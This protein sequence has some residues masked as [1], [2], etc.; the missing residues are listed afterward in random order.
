MKVWLYVLAASNH[1]DRIRCR[2]PWRVDEHLIY[3]GPCK[4][5]IRACLRGKY[6]TSATSHAVAAEDLFIVG[7]NG[8][9]AERVRKI[10]WWGKLLEVMTFAYAYDHLRG[11][12]FEE[13]RRHRATPL[14]VRPIIDD[15]THIGYE[16][17]SEEHIKNNEWISDVVSKRSLGNVVLQDRKLISRQVRAGEIFDRDCCLLLENRYFSSGQGIAFDDVAL[18]ILRKVQPEKLGIDEYALFGLTSNGRPNG[19][20]GTYLQM[21]GD[22]AT[23]FISWL[24]AK[25]LNMSGIERKP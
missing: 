2:V 14:H 16:H 15:G 22:D 17:V 11:E 7:V 9:N 3:F 18:E 24:G 20:R 12:R 4:K 6:L 1:P 10:V 5:R 13:L 8:G 23:R 21:S 25:T 19:L